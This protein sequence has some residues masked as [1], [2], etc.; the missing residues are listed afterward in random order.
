MSLF[1]DVVF[2][3][4]LPQ[5][6]TYSVPEQLRETVRPG[7]QVRA[8]L[9]K[10]TAR[11]FIV[12]VHD[13]PLAP[14]AIKDIDSVLEAERIIPADI[15][16]L[17]GRLSRRNHSSW[18]AF[19]RSAAWPAESESQTR[20]SLTEAGRR[21]LAGGELSGEEGKIAA[22]LAV[23]TYSPAHFKKRTV[24][25]NGAAVLARLIRKGL[26]E[27]AVREKTVRRRTAA[28]VR[29]SPV[30]LDLDFSLDEAARRAAARID[31]AIAEGRTLSA[32]FV[33]S[34]ARRA[35]AYLQCIRDTLARGRQV[36]F[37][38]P[39]I[40]MSKAVSGALA[41]GLGERAVLLHS[42][43]T[44]R[45]RQDALRCVESLPAAVI[46]GPRSAL[47]TPLPRLGLI[48][49]DEES[50]ESYVQAENPAYDARVGAR[51]RAA[52]ARIPIVLGSDAPTVESYQRAVRDGSLLEIAGNGDSAV[53]VLLDDRRERGLLA[54]PLVERI[55]SSLAAGRRII[56]FVRRKGFASFLL[57][58]RC[59]HVP[60]CPRCNI[61]LTYFQKNRRLQCRYCNES[62][63]A[64]GSCPRCGGRILEPRGAGLEAVEEELKRIFPGARAAGFD[65]ERVRTRAE[66]EKVLERFAGG[67][68]NV[69]VGTPLLAHQ[70]GVAPASLVAVLN[71]E[72]GLGFSDFQAAQRTY[73]D[74]RRFLRFCDTA[75]PAAEAVLQT[76]L[77]DHPVLRAAAAGDYAAFYREEIEFRR[78]L[79]YPP[80]AALAEIGFWGRDAQALTRLAADLAAGLREAGIPDVLGPSPVQ[81]RGQRGVQIVA[82]A[83][84]AETL[85]EP[86][87]RL[88]AGVRVRKTVV[89][90]D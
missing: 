34:S 11:G 37:L 90:F 67:A 32:L 72:H 38:Y 40:G 58:P 85:D 2:P 61:A 35:S 53:A 5:A 9:G 19:L 31:G 62:R 4:P 57:C 68:V 66:R 56:L 10:K 13:Q 43:L 1:A 52:A 63:P 17:A 45:E 88:L 14:A 69:L 59:G 79:G 44:G 74:I 83:A 24:A 60:R 80:F 84:T 86:L 47:F 6:F 64:P 22:L 76:S 28:A 55:R 54:G 42:R 26:A 75:D 49:V 50:D 16:D 20:A 33:G 12:R 27:T 73:V 82:K 51:W 39:E 78:I 65:S 71:P 7:L 25:V 41:S 15:L 29:P 8:P 48:I 3:L 30:Q 18:G 46:A 81:S 70:A 87:S 36:L 77:P 23:K 89:R 21:A